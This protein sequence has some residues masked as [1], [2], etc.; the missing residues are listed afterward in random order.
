MDKSKT[1]PMDKL[2]TDP[3]DKSKTDPMDKLKTDPMDKSNMD[4][5]AIDEDIEKYKETKKDRQPIQK[6]KNKRNIN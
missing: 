1:D 3:M 6:Y 5:S 4:P 2:K